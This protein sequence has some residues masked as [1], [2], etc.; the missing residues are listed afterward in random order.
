M[1]KNATNSSISAS[2]A[3]LSLAL[4]Q[5]AYNEARRRGDG[6]TSVVYCDFDSERYYNK[7]LVADKRSVV[8]A[9]N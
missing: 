9:L 5:Q 7:L 1:L 2:S 6:K 4:M 8:L 3:Q